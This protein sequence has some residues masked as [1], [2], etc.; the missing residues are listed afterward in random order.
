VTIQGLINE[1]SKTSGNSVEV[2]EFILW[3]I[4]A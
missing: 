2:K 4:G 1:V 3:K